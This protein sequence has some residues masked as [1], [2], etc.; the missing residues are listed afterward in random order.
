MLV[1]A[2]E[3]ATRLRLAVDEVVGVAE[4]RQ[5]VRQL[6][7]FHRCEG[8]VLV[9]D[10]SRDELRAHHGS[11]LRPP[12]ARGVHDDLGLDAARFGH[13]RPHLA[14]R[15]ELDTR[16]A[17]ARADLR[18]EIAGRTGQR[19][20]RRVRVEIAVAVQVDGAVER[21]RAGLRQQAQR[22]SRRGQLHLQSDRPRA[23]HAA[24][25]LGQRLRAGCDAHA[26]DA[27][28]DPELPVQLDAV[29]TE[30]HHRRRRV[31]LGDQAGRMAGRA[32]RERALVEQDE[33]AP[34][35]AR[36]VVG[37]AAAGDAASD[38]D[39]TSAISHAPAPVS[40]RPFSARLD[41]RAAL[42]EQTRARRTTP[43]R[44]AGTA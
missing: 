39:R 32:A 38:D 27:L 31:E 3:R 5:V 18:A 6:V 22:L 44:R 1:A 15:P 8:D 36:Q 21:L 23:R 16:H 10:R 11:H 26:A 34:P 37:H 42:K 28:E 7:A 43:P 33:V 4:A 12:H 40:Q 35:R 29:A 2:E 24:L 14:P 9:L 19:V 13:H 20:G 41:A 30:A 25:Q 17:L